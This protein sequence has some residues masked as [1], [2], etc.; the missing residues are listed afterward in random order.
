MATCTAPSCCR[1]RRVMSKSHPNLRAPA[2]SS[3]CRCGDGSPHEDGASGT[4]PLVLGAAE[5]R[6]RVLRPIGVMWL[7]FAAG[8]SGGA[9]AELPRQHVELTSPP[10]TSTVWNPVRSVDWNV[11]NPDA[12]T[13]GNPE[14]A[15]RIIGQRSR[16]EFGPPAVRYSAAIV[17][18]RPW[19]YYG[20]VLCFSG[21]VDLVMDLPPSNEFASRVGKAFDAVFITADQ[22]IVESINVGD[23]GSLAAGQSFR[24]CGLVAGREEVTNKLGGR[25]TQLLVLGWPE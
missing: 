15:A 22:T 19:E 3:R 11:D 17:L 4:L 24:M 18:K 25:V 6:A 2:R 1:R 13:N 9:D 14:L 7:L 5:T 16:A 12:L 23:S 20:F 10:T 8:C 21:R